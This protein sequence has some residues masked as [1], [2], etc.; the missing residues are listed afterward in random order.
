MCLLLQLSEFRQQLQISAKHLN[1]AEQ[2]LG[3]KERSVEAVEQYA[4]YLEHELSQSHGTHERL[5]TQYDADMLG[6]EQQV[7][8]LQVLDADL[9]NTY[10]TAVPQL[11]DQPWKAFLP[12]LSLVCQQAVCFSV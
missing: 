6:M 3:H 1:A 4:V 2:L 8:D 10:I 9:L 7:S 5:R 11:D 12:K